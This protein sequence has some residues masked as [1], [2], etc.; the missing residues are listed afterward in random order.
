M[1]IHTSKSRPE[2]E[3][4]YGCR[5]FS[6]TG[7]T[8]IS[9]VDWDVWLKFATQIDFYLLK[10]MPSLNL[11]PGV[12][13]RLCGCYLK[14]SIWRHNSAAD[15]PT[16]AIFSRQM[17]N[18][19]LMTTHMSNSKTEIEFQYG[20]GPFFETGSSFISAAD[21]DSSL[22]FGMRIHFHFLKQMPSLNLNPGV[23]F[24]LYGC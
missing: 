18:G 20:S 17:Q 12:D 8:F 2:I 6:E 21:W 19:M 15:C 3:F 9:A 14:T 23:D 1:T 11:N 24:R 22:K 7:S 13:F 10:Q 4:Q 16:S 5:P